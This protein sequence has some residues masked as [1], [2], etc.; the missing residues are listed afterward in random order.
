MKQAPL[1]ANTAKLVVASR[2]LP[3]SLARVGAP[4]R[5]ARPPPPPAE[6][7]NAAADATGEDGAE[8]RVGVE[9]R[10]MVEAQEDRTTRRSPTSHGL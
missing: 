8:L 3:P 4:L 7:G 9:A 1:G 10:A 2:L 5:S 6:V